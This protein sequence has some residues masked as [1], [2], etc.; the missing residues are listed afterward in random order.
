MKGLLYHKYYYLSYLQL[1]QTE[2][3]KSLQ[4]LLVFLLTFTLSNK[5]Q[6][7]IPFTKTEIIYGR[8]DG[9]ALTMIMLAP[10]E[11]SNGKAIISTV[12]GN[13]KS[14]YTYATQFVN[15]GKMYVN[16]GY[17][18]FAVIHGSQPRY[19]IPD[20]VADLKR[21]VRFIRY[22][23]AQYHIDP[24]HI[25]IMGASSGGHLSL[26]T[27]LTDNVTDT[28][29]NDPVDTV[30]ARVQAVAVFFP[31]TDFLHWGNKPANLSSARAGLAKAG[32]AS[33]FE[34]KE[35]NETTNT[36]IVLRDRKKIAG[37]LK[38]TSPIYSVTADD[39]PVLIIHGDADPT[40]PLQQ[41]ETLIEK[42][43]AANIPN[44]L[45]I[46]KDGGHGWKNMEVEEKNFIDWFDKYLK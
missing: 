36:Y 22:N 20:E 1:S 35:W 25:G 41:S 34:Y 7:T 39:P 45:I 10:A 33:A 23:A 5:A 43:K 16:N 24:T 31:P 26:M 9:M 29:S 42:L 18:V 2:Y 37:I 19:T 38:E 15:R 21:A 11:H 32:V 27:G 30:S 8:K 14:S 3:M 6:D 46:K 12:S 13:W 40:V 4:L 44:K 17:T 28:G